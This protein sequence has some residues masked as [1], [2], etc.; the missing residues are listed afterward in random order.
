MPCPRASCNCREVV[1]RAKP[2]A[3]PSD[4]PQLGAATAARSRTATAGAFAAAATTTAMVMVVVVVVVTAARIAAAGRLGAAGLLTT[5]GAFAAA[6]VVVV[7]MATRLAAAR[8]TAGLLGAARLL[9]AAGPLGAAAPL[10]ARAGALAAMADVL[11]ALAARIANAM[12][13]AATF[14]T[15]RRLSA[16][17][18][19]SVAA[20]VERLGA[21]GQRQSRHEGESDNSKTTNHGEL[22]P[23]EKHP[24]SSIP[25]CALRCRPATVRQGPTWRS[26]LTMLGWQL[27][28]VVS[29]A[30]NGWLSQNSHSP[31]PA[32]SNASGCAGFAGSTDFAGRA[33]RA[34]WLRRRGV[35]GRYMRQR[36]S[37]L[38]DR[39]EGPATFAQPRAPPWGSGLPL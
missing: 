10:A 14:V 4:T 24:G 13:M 29:V 32:M 37:R 12:T 19:F 31:P 1:E 11:A 6:A 38:P 7:P 23:K 2:P 3:S 36:R 34:E 35:A 9:G 33:P 30:R 26:R 8:G 39:A 21:G 20:A 18:S 25:P 28:N 15:T 27:L 17:A 5:A 16:T 22:L